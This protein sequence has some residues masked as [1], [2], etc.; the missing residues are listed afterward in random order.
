MSITRL[1]AVARGAY[2]A[3]VAIDNPWAHDGPW[4]SVARAVIM[5]ALFVAGSLASHHVG[6]ADDCGELA[7]AVMAV[8]EEAKAL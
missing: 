6:R 2:Y 7:R 3:T 8:L 4:N 1:G 5:E